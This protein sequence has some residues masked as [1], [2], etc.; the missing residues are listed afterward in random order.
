MCYYVTTLTVTN[1]SENFTPLQPS[2][3]DVGPHCEDR[4]SF[5]WFNVKEAAID[6]HN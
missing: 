6:L 5:L 1:Y 4:S 2:M 3:L